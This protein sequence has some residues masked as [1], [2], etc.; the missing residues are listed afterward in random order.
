[1]FELYC[2]LNLIM[3]KNNKL[4]ALYNKVSFSCIAKKLTVFLQN[5]LFVSIVNRKIYY[6]VIKIQSCI[7]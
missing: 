5:L 4:V 2:I 3:L 6:Y 7:C 1:M